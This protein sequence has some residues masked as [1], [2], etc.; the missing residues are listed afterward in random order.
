M[1]ASFYYPSILK[2]NDLVGLLHRTQ[3]VRYNNNCLIIEERAQI[4]HY[5]PFVIRVQVA[6]GFVKENEI[7]VMV[8]G[9][10]NKQSLFLPPR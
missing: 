7:R 4:L 1:H 10:G 6:G 5:P 9:P 8:Y 2:D 3:S